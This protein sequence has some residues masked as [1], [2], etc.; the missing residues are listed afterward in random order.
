MVG[1]FYRS[2]APD[3]DP[4]VEIG[5]VVDEGDVVGLVEAMKVFNEIEAEVRG[6]VVEIPAA[7][8]Q[9]VNRGDPLVILELL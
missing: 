2:P 7:N 4:F 6:R 9:L 1:I 8:E 3:A 5:S